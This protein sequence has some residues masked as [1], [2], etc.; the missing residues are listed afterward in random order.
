MAS[1]TGAFS[2]GVNDIVLKCRYQNASPKACPFW[3]RGGDCCTACPIL[4][5]LGWPYARPETFAWPRSS[6]WLKKCFKHCYRF[7]KWT[8]F[9]WIRT[10][11]CFV[12]ALAYIVGSF[13]VI[14]PSVGSTFLTV[15]CKLFN[16]YCTWQ[17]WHVDQWPWKQQRTWSKKT[18]KRLKRS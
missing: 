8:S 14:L 4:I 11:K 16:R 6:N 3:C 15:L 18:Q 5:P 1:K 10:K 17:T 2:L 12:Y 9:T 7:K 13:L